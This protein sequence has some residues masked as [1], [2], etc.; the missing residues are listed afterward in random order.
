MAGNAHPV[1]SATVVALRNQSASRWSAA[2]DG[3]ATASISLLAPSSDTS[4][5]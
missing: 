5:S 2:N 4:G 1:R 3:N